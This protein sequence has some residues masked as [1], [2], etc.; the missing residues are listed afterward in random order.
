MRFGADIAGLLQETI[1]R[2][3]QLELPV[4]VGD[5]IQKIDVQMDGTG[6]P[7]VAKETQGRSGKG[8]DGRAYTREAK[9]GCVFTQTNIDDQG[10]PVRDEEST[11]YTG[12]IETAAEFSRRIYTEAQQRGWARAQ[13]K[14]VM[15]DGADWIW[16][17]CQEQFP[18]VSRLWISITLASTS[19]ISEANFTPTTRR[20]NGGG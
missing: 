15:G 1:Q 17:I 19:G 20:L 16:N 10:R 2:A 6:L 4:A 7:V 9:L 11:T 5:P 18:G 13:V 12:A 3:M 14:A 8:E